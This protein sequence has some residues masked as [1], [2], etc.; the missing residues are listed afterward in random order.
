MFGDAICSFNP[1]YGQGMTVAALQAVALRD[2]VRRRRLDARRYF[3][4]AA[5][6]VG[7]A[8]DLATGSDLSLPEVPG[9]R[10]RKVRILNAYVERVLRVAEDDP[11]VARAFLRT[12]A[13]LDRPPS[14]LRPTIA[15][16]V[17]RAG[18]RGAPSDRPPA[19]PAGTGSD[20]RIG[21]ATAGAAGRGERRLRPA[22]PHQLKGGP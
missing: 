22:R 5:G 15:A 1:I 16:R 21:V 20:A 9:P 3:R 2:E 18:L 10:S 7:D 11:T 6:P 19:V 12:I 14:L 8:W 4:A 13:M 17:A